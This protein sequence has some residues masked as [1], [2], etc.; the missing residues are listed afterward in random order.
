MKRFILL[1]ALALFFTSLAVAA[2]YYQKSVTNVSGLSANTTLNVNT[3]ADKTRFQILSGSG[4]APTNGTFSVFYQV[5]SSDE[6]IS[7]GDVDEGYVGNGS[8]SIQKIR[9]QPNGMDANQT[10]SGFWEGWL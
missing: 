10:W 7:I 1:L 3:D 2:D 4:V 8:Y 9:I 6:W 5:W